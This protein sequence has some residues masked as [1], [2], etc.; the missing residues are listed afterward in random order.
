MNDGALRASFDDLRNDL[1][2]VARDAE[3][4]LKATANMSG[5]RMDEI[6]AR[7]QDTLHRAYDHLYERNLRMRQLA[8]DAD[9]FVHEHAWGSVAA[10]AGLGMLLGIVISRSLERSDGTTF[11]D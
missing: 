7:T 6:R 9:S 4:L 5:G 8:R 3:A 10:A 1:Q 11:E 2:A